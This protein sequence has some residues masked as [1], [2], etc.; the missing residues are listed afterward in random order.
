MANL[1][2]ENEVET[3]KLSKQIR[4]KYPLNLVGTGANGN[5]SVSGSISGLEPVVDVTTTPVTLT[6][7][8]SNSV[9]LLDVASGTT[10]TLPTDAAGLTY[11][12]VVATTVTSNSYKVIIGSASSYFIG[13]ID[14][15]VSTGTRKNFY[16]D[17]SSLLSINLN[18]ST[19]GGLQGGTFTVICLKAGLWSAQGS[20]EG[21]GTVA[22]PFATS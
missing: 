13:Q 15:P 20:V 12:F 11:T 9:I 3:V 17:G 22:T 1:Y 10:I 18:G 16:G 19:T 5:L 6:A 7:A 14:V 4:S 2:I 8:Q 21:S